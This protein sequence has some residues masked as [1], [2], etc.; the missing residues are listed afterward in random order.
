MAKR[1]FLI[2][3]GLGGSGLD[4]WQTWLSHELLERDE[5]VYYPEFPEKDQ[6]QRKDWMETLDQVTAGIPEEEEVTVIAH[7]LACIL[8]F[9][10]VCSAPRRTMKQAILVS[11]VSPATDFAEVESFFPIPEN[12]EEVVSGAERTVFIHSSAD[13]FCSVEDAVPYMKLGL[14]NLILPNSGHINV[15]SGHGPWPMML[16]L[17]LRNSV[18]LP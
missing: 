11:P 12:L 18:I 3:Y 15:E 6:P 13:P 14:P 2:L 8:W 9:H 1:S 16:E 10:Y 7:S 5:T 17:C 4:H